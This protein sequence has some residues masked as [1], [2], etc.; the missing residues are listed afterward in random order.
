MQVPHSRMHQT[1][2]P[3][4][5]ENEQA[6]DRVPIQMRDALSAANRI[7]LKQQL[8]GERGPILGDVHCT[9]SPRVPLGVG[10]LALRAAETPQ[11]VPM[12]PEALT[13]DIARP[14]SHCLCGFFVVYHGL[15][16]QRALA[17]CQEKNAGKP[18]IMAIYLGSAAGLWLSE[19][20]LKRGESK[21]GSADFD[22][23]S[24]VAKSS[25]VPDN[26]GFN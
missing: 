6:H 15:I 17:V 8:Q 1:G 13:I 22:N 3:F 14:A 2:T 18:E 12:F 10:P 16:I 19:Y 21:Y 4:P 26:T 25:N 9:Q 23:P 5:R 20:G 24:S 11:A 7:A